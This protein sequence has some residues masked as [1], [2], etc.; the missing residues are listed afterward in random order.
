MRSVF[1][2]SRI[3]A[4]QRT[5]LDDIAIARRKEDYLSELYVR[6]P[7]LKFTSIARVELLTQSTDQGLTI[8][9]HL[10]EAPQLWLSLGWD[11][12]RYSSELHNDPF[13]QLLQR[14]EYDRRTLV[15]DVAMASDSAAVMEQLASGLPLD[16]RTIELRREARRSRRHLSGRQAELASNDQLEF[17]IPPRLSLIEHAKVLARVSSMKKNSVNL[18]DV[19]EDS[20]SFVNRPSA[21]AIPVQLVLHRPPG[22]TH[23]QNGRTLQE[24]MDRGV[25]IK[26]FVGVRFSG[27][28]ARVADLELLAAVE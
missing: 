28:D 6:L 12:N 1:L 3:I 20:E 18:F 21:Q 9:A 15:V 4:G 22:K 17:E 8:E 25:P 16:K 24:A 10:H 11:R 5:A 26:L 27:I 7:T 14:L 13:L 2:E 23:L 19:K